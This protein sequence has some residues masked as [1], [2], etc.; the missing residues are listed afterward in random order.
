MQQSADRP[1]GPPHSLDDFLQREIFDVPQLDCL[2]LVVRNTGQG[3]LQ[4]ADR[5]V[6][7]G[8]TT[9]RALVI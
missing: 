1:L 2:S 3:D 8:R 7:R 5:F 9:G 4:S 6:G